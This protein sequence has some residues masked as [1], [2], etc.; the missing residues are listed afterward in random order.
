MFLELDRYKTMLKYL[1]CF[2]SECNTQASA[3]PNPHHY[4]IYFYSH[5]FLSANMPKL[6]NENQLNLALQAIQQ[7]TFLSIKCVASIYTVNHIILFQCKRGTPSRHNC[8]LNMQNLTDL[9]KD[10]VVHKILELDIQRFFFRFHDVGD[11]ANKLLHDCD[12]LLV[13]KNWIFNFISCC[14]K[15]K[16]VFSHKYNYQQTLCKDLEIINKWFE[17]IHNFKTKYGIIDENI[18]NFNKTGFLMN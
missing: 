2:T 1:T 3:T 8:K 7:D 13:G 17:L 15:L 18:Y 16:N 9:E 4:H 12:T 14:L 11:M 5:I 10:T 6:F